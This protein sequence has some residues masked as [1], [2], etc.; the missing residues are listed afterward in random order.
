MPELGISVDP[1]NEHSSNPSPSF[2]SPEVS[3]SHPL[4]HPIW[5]L[6]PLRSKIVQH[7]LYINWALRN[8]QDYLAASVRTCFSC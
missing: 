6:Q 3:I 8:P 1:V 7:P 5:S 2:G 4:L